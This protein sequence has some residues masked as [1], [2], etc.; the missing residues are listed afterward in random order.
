MPNP[1]KFHFCQII[2]KKLTI[3]IKMR[4]RYNYGQ[5]CENLHGM[6]RGFSLERSGPPWYVMRIIAEYD[7]RARRHRHMKCE[8]RGDNTL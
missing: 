5:L 6:L 2:L 3:H 8:N 4:I 7:V 1:G